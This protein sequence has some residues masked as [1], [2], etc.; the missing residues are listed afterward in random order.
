[1]LFL[2][3]YLY[4]KT[5]RKS[6]LLVVILSVYALLLGISTASK[7]VVLM[8]TVPIIAFAWMDR[9][10][11]ILVSSVMFAGFGVI[12]TSL[13]RKIVYVS[14]GFTTASFTDLGTLGTLT[15]TF[16]MVDFS[17]KLFLI[18]VAIAARVDNFQGLFLAS[19][20]NPDVIGGSWAVLLKTILYT[21]A[22]F[23]HD[24]THMEY[25]GHTVPIGFYNVIASVS[26][27]LIMS[28]SNNI[29]MIL[30]FALFT[31]ITLVVLEKTLLRTA[32]NHK[33]LLPIAQAVLFY[34][35]LLFYVAPGR[36][37]FITF[38]LASIVISFIPAIKLRKARLP[39]FQ[40]HSQFQK[41]CQL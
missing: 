9:R 15:E 41:K 35:T 11:I 27:R 7:S 23:D 17:P 19:E 33:V 40:K 31:T 14:N 3:G 24:A 28:A 25:L 10:W 2:I 29:T 1:M 18:F 16:S 20:F 39:Q 8:I 4:I 37:I 32:Y 30:P 38:F 5:A 22:E 6:F 34:L 26:G 12:M 13:S 21:W 36:P